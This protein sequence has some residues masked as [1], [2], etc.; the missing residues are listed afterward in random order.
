V[1]GQ[2]KEMGANEAGEI[3]FGGRKT[4]NS[5]LKILTSGKSEIEGRPI[6]GEAIKQL[7]SL[8]VG[9]TTRRKKGGGQGVGGP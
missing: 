4:R 9:D 8:S 6:R 1:L 5:L 3:D 7:L 2:F